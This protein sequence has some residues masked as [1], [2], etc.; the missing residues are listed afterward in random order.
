VILSKGDRI[1]A[2]DLPLD[3]PSGEIGNTEAAP[4]PGDLISLEKLEDYH[5]RKVLERTGGV[6]EAA[7]ILGIDDGTIYRKRKKMGAP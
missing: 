3:G 7:R 1:G 6:A 5:I 2:E 4:Q